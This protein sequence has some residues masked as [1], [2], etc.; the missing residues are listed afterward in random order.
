VGKTLKQTISG[1]A[2][3]VLTGG[4]TKNAAAAFVNEQSKKLAT[5]AKSAVKSTN[6]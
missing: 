5:E 4:K 1:N 6:L 2:D 3:K